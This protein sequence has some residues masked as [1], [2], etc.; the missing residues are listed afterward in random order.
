[1]N[2]DNKASVIRVLCEGLQELKHQGAVTLPRDK[3]ARAQ[4]LLLYQIICLFDGD[5]SLRSQAEKDM[6]LLSNWIDDL[7][8]IRDNLGWPHEIDSSREQTSCPKSWE[9]SIYTEAGL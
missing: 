1:M 7:C 4:A 2:Q 8:K 3:L 5:L 6:P 9:V